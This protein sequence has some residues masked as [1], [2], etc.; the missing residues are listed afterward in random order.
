MLEIR[1]NCEYCD[2]NLAPDSI[3]A[4]ICTYECTFCK[5]CV[6]DI[7][8][9]VCPNCGGGFCPR[10]VRPQMAR[11]QGLSIDHQPASTERVN[12]KYSKDELLEFSAAIKHIKPEHR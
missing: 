11:R 5:T 6:D 8:E 7:L 12:T 9:N 2:K 10:P 1:P 4:M 3:E